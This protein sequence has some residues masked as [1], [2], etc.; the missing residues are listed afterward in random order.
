MKKLIGIMFYF[1][2]LTGCADKAEEVAMIEE[3]SEPA[4]EETMQPMLLEYMWCDF[5]PKPLKRSMAA[6][7]ADFNEIVSSSEYK[8]R[9]HGVTYP[10]LKQIY[11]MRFG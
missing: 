7:T 8:V 10:H 2:I 6:L 3:V 5:G 1:L 9:V 11:M 4:S